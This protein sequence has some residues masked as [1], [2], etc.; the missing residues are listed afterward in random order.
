MRAVLRLGLV[1]TTLA[2]VVGLVG[3]ATA[4]PS[5]KKYEAYVMPANSTATSF[6]LTLT[7][8]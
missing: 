7:V 1:A 4:A 2:C 8:Q 5:T 6:T 3:S